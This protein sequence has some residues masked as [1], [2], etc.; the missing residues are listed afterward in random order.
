[1]NI[2]ELID[3]AAEAGKIILENGGETYRVEET[4]CKICSAYGDFEIETFATPTGIII[5]INCPDNGTISIVKRI[6][7]RT[8]NLEKVKRVND[9]SRKIVKNP[10][11]I[12]EL[13]E[14]LKSI[15]ISS[16]YSETCQMIFAAIAAQSFT[17]L[18]GGNLKDSFVSFIIGMSIHKI[19][20]FMNKINLNS[21][22]INIVGGAIAA[23]IASLSI[24]LKIEINLD[25]VIIGSI[26]LLVPGLTITNAI[27][28][29]LAGD[30]VSGMTRTVEAFLVAIAIAIGSGIILKFLFINLGGISI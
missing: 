9:L 27:R 5:S 24:Y 1:M 21:F 28:D 23:G 7:K 20:S 13:K 3:A 16:S 15:K 6:K 18:F 29:T 8:V 10:I 19:S 2:N 22:F 26:M 11:P 25:K 30:L 14:E 4:I 17:L 12:N